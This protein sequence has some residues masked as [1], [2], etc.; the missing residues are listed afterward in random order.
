MV[1]GNRMPPPH[2]CFAVAFGHTFHA[3]MSLQFMSL[4]AVSH[5]QSYTHA[6]LHVGFTEDRN[7]SMR[8][9]S[10]AS[11]IPHYILTTGIWSEDGASHE[12]F[13]HACQI[14]CVQCSLVPC[15]LFI[16]QS[17]YCVSLCLACIAHS[18]TSCSG[19]H[20]GSMPGHGYWHPRI[21]D[22]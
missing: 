1:S 16:V 11:D 15:S 22:R 9:S 21:R 13:S 14:T 5:C 4:H 3:V 8:I 20:S 19:H 6:V 2:T 12:S 7:P 10:V 17:L 18:S